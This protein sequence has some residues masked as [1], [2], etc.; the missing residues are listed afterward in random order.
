LSLSTLALEGSRPTAGRGDAP[1]RGLLALRYADLAVLALAL[2]LFLAVGASMLGYAAAAAAWLV[3][4]GV[5]LLAERGATRAMAEGVRRNALGMIAGA[6]LARLWI[7]TL[8]ILLVGTLGNRDAGLAAAL[9]SLVLVTV[10]LATRA[11][12]HVFI[13]PEKTR[14]H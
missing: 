12:I 2:P 5:Q 1:S 8:A 6:T 11:I 10:S 9:L 13:E 4:R 7:V 3:Q 14:E